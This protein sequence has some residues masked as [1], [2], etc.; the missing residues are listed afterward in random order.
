MSRSFIATILAGALAVTGLTAAPARADAEDVAKALA[1]IAAVAIIADAVRDNDRDRRRHGIVTRSH[2]NHGNAYGNAYR[3]G[4][5]RPHVDTRRGHGHIAPR[6]L[7][8]R[9]Q[10]NQLPRRCMVRVTGRNINA[11]AFAG[12]CLARNDVNMRR[13]PDRC[14]IRMRGQRGGQSYYA[15]ACL[16]SHGYRA[17]RR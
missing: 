8:R 4:H 10:V 3:R 14:E 13:L 5:D 7:P 6:P 2:R 9:A 1:G 16:R 17:A 12:R 15:A 11:Q